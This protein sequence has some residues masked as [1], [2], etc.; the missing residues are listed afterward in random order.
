MRKIIIVIIL[1][2][3][4]CVFAQAPNWQWAAKAGGTSS[5]RGYGIIIDDTGNC[6][7]IG[8]FGGTA[9]FGSYSL[10]SS[11]YSDVFV[12][13]MD[14]TGNWLWAINAGGSA[15][16]TGY[17]ITID[18]AG[19][20]Y[21]TGSFMGTA[22]FGSYSLTSNGGSDIFVVKL[23]SSV[24][25]E[26]EISPAEIGLSNYPNPFNPETTISFSTTESTES[27]ELFIYNIKG[28]K[29]KTFLSFPNWGLGTRSVV[30]DGTDVNN[31]PVSSGIYLYKLAVNNKTKAVK[32]MILL[33]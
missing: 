12:A 26:N 22:T 32:K 29:I 23:N 28:Q 30:W 7:V 17:E 2:I 10:I 14:A 6:Y 1:F 20:S 4:V 13:K 15:F 8:S 27:T 31:Q 21:V 11:G 5:D 19:N 24:F 25:A 16:E 3:A 9:T 18:D 33:R